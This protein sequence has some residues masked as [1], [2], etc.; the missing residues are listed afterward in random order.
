MQTIIRDYRNGRALTDAPRGVK[1]IDTF[2]LSAAQLRTQFPAIYQ[3]LLEHVKPERDQN[4][5]ASYRD[6][7]WIHGE[8]AK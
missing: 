8:P 7:W 4:N 5:R 6:N 1:D 3:R 2:G